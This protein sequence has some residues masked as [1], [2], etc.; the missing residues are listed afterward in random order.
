ML[1]N[2]ERAPEI[3]SMKY[4]L[5]IQAISLGVAFLVQLYNYL[6]PEPILLI[7]Y[8]VCYIIFYLAYF[9]QSLMMILI[10]TVPHKKPGPQDTVQMHTPQTN[11]KATSGGYTT[12]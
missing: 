11:T 7:V 10:F 1:P 12:Y 2:N 4:K 8:L 9:F 5:I 6:S 3:K